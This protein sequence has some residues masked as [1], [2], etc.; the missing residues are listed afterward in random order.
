MKSS[1]NPTYQLNPLFIG[2]KQENKSNF[3]INSPNKK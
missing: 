3:N 1:I 2:L